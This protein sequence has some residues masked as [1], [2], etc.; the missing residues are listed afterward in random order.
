MTDF[1]EKSPTNP[2]TMELLVGIIHPSSVLPKR[3]HGDEI[4]KSVKQMG[5]IQPLI[6]KPMHDR[7]G[8]FELIDGAGR[9]ESLGATEFVRVE[10]VEATPSKVFDISDAT[11]RRKNRTANEI[12][13]F[14]EGWLQ[15]IIKENGTK[16]GAQAELAKRANRSEGLISQYRAIRQLF[17]KLKTLAPN[18]AFSA[19]KLWDLN[20]LYQLSKLL[21]NPKLLEIALELENKP[22]THL[23][24]L[25]SLV[26]DIQLAPTEPTISTD[27]SDLKT[28]QSV[29][30]KAHENLPKPTSKK[31][32][33]LLSKATQNLNEV[34]PKLNDLMHEIE[35]DTEK[36]SST[37]TLTTVKHVLRLLKKLQSYTEALT[38][39]TKPNQN[40]DRQIG[41]END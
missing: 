9:L 21:D 6:V 22:E 38:Q 32:A 27:G 18:V 2:Q 25:K 31:L 19:L 23:E 15:A 17:E 30:A 40:C 4:K 3:A 14:Q 39:T 36:Y 35:T 11:F 34:A 13:E 16:E 8:Q 12:A 5:V 1:G 24:D 7:P 10:I 41:E 20:R 26:N 28:G 37:Q 33:N 29:A